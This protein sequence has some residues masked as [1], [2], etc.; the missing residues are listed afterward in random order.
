MAAQRKP[1]SSRATA[2]VATVERLPC[3]V[4]WRWR[5]CRRTW[6]LPGALGDVGRDVRL[7]G[8]DALADAGGVL[9]VPGGLDQQPAGVPVAGLGDVAAVALVAG[10]VLAGGQAEEAHQLARVAKRR[11]SPISASSPSAV[12]V[13]MPRKQ[14]SQRTGSLHGSRR[15]DL[16][17]AGVERG[18]LARRRRRGG[19]ACAPAPRCASGSSSRWRRTHAMWRLVQAFLPSR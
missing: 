4:R 10:G 14:H 7:D 2:T 1:A 19:R 6:A 13:V 16:A 11:K 3:W 12:S 9:V 8:G 17:R 18:E 15:G 5:W